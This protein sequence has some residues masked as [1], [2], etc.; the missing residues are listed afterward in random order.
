MKNIKFKTIFL[1]FLL[2]TCHL[3]LIT[4]SNAE[5]LERIV[6][7][8][9]DDVILLSEFQGAL[10][11]AKETDSGVSGEIV[12]NEMINSMLM[13]SE[14]KKFRTGDSDSNHQ[15]TTDNR[16]VIREY[17]DRRIKAFIHI[18]YEEIEY[19]FDLNRELFAG[20]EFS[21][22]RDG[23]EEYLVK[24]EL[25]AKLHEYIKELKGKARIRIQLTDEE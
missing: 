11:S 10:Q 17:I 6:A 9:N 15:N 16:T 5:V 19:Y 4:I 18:P 2:V 3:S 7:V 23:I 20:K 13:L 25:S 1:I 8:V 14:A 21:D 24:K 12:L 22:V